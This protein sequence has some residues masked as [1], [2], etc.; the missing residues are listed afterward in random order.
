MGGRL[1]HLTP[2]LKIPVW[3]RR[4]VL[5]SLPWVVRFLSF[6]LWEDGTPPPHR[7]F[8][9]RS[10]VLAVAHP[11]PWS[12]ASFYLPSQSLADSRASVTF[13]QNSFFLGGG[14]ACWVP[15]PSRIGGLLGLTRAKTPYLPTYPQAAQRSEKR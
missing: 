10:V 3:W 2:L 13:A 1:V 6:F 12:S 5:P 4:A 9:E 14:S 11:K 8:K 7:D 15:A